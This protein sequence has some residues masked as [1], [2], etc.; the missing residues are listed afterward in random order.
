MYS[1]TL[2]AVNVHFSTASTKRLL[3]LV[4]VLILSLQAGRRLHN[5]QRSKRNQTYG[6]LKRARILLC[7][8]TMM[9]TE[10]LIQKIFKIY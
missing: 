1:D 6:S 4:N 2:K 3:W 7:K 5:E 10:T 8:A 9:H